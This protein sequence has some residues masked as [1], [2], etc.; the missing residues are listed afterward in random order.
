MHFDMVIKNVHMRKKKNYCEL[1]I[2]LVKNV[3]LKYFFQ[4]DWILA[5][6]HL[7]QLLGDELTWSLYPD[8]LRVPYV[9]LVMYA[10]SSRLSTSMRLP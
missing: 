9:T 7:Q 1:T 8:F 2:F 10:E 4:N 6:L 5:Q 3:H